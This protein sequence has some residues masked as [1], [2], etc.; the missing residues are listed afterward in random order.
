MTMRDPIFTVIQR[1]L[2][3]LGLYDAAVD[4]E[5][6]PGMAGGIDRA[7]A[8]IEK[9]RVTATPAGALLYP[10]LKPDYA[11]IRDQGPLPRHL[12]EMLN[13]LGTHEVAGPGNSP[14]I[15]GW[16]AELLAAGIDLRSSYPG[17]SVA[18]CGLAIAIAMLR[19][20]RP[21]V[22]NPLWALNWSKWGED[23]GQPELGD[24]LIFMRDGGGHVALYVGED[25]DWFHVL[26]GNQSDSVSIMRIAKTRLK[27]CRQPAY[28]NKPASV[29]PRLV[30]TTGAIS[31]NEA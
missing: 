20:D 24:V 8:L 6:G 25:R 17:D 10:G 13:L 18:W 31:V 12:S 2:A 19:A 21:V 4:D 7:L 30:R 23:G 27:A 11:W 3:A 29:R 14:V 16:T 1:R 15:M 26:G 28:K 22:D 5:W 9:A